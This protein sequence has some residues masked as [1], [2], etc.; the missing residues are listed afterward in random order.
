M[1]ASSVDR[2]LAL[3]DRGEFHA[4]IDLAEMILDADPDDGRTWELKG[5]LHD[6]VGDFDAARRALE[7]ATSLVPLQPLARCVLAERY[8]RSGPTDLAEEIFLDVARTGA[9]SPALLLRVA[10]ELHGLGRTASAVEACRRSA[11]LDPYAAA[12]LYALGYYLERAGSPP[13]LAEGALRKAL[14]Y[15]PTSSKYR[16]GL[17][18]FLHRH[19]RYD[20]AY[21]TANGL[22]TRQIAAMGCVCCLVRL[23]DTFER[24]GDEA[25][26]THCRSRLEALGLTDAS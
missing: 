20:D 15:A 8:A 14:D 22:T 12:P 3:R 19:G 25:R 7:Q 17:A 2:V 9:A 21:E 23:L 6:R 4:A 10:A 26:A 1:T 13:N 5:L 11:A 24:H 18:S 16:V